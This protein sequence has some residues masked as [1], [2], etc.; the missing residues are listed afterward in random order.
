MFHRILFDPHLSSHFSTPFFFQKKKLAFWFVY[1]FFAVV[2]VD[3][4]HP[5]LFCKVCYALAD[6]LNNLFAGYEPS[7]SSKSAGNTVRLFSFVRGSLGTN[8]D[9]L[10]TTLDASEVKDT[11]DVERLTSHLFSQEREASAV[12]GKTMQR[13]SHVFR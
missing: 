13:A 2:P 6:W 8:V 11:T 4:S 9:D 12:A 10:A 5:L 3:K 1:L 7:L